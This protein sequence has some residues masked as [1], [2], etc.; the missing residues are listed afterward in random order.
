MTESERSLTDRNLAR[1]PSDH[2]ARAQAYLSLIRHGQASQRSLLL[3]AAHGDTVAQNLVSDQAAVTRVRSGQDLAEL[4]RLPVESLDLSDCG[5]LQDQDLAALG[6]LPLQS[7]SLKN[8]YQVTDD[9]LQHLASLPLKDLDLS[10]C[11]KILGAGLESLAQLELKALR[12]DGC[13]Q[14][15]PYAFRFLGDFQLEHLSVVRGPDLDE[16]LHSLK[17]DALRSL[18]AGFQYSAVQNLQFKEFPA[19][20]TLALGGFPEFEPDEPSMFN[21]PRLSQIILER[22]CAPYASFYQDLQQRS[23]LELAI[24]DDHGL[25]EE[26]LLNELAPMTSLKSLDI[27][28]HIF[29]DMLQALSELKLEQLTLETHNSLTEAGLQQLNREHLRK[30]T[31]RNGPSLTDN[32]LKLFADSPLE[33]LALLGNGV[34]GW[35]FQYLSKTPLNT[36]YWSQVHLPD[37]TRLD[38]SPL[39]ELQEL[40]LD[41]PAAALDVTRLSLE[42]PKLKTLSLNPKGQTVDSSLSFLKAPA[43]EA[44]KIR[45]YRFDAQALKK[46]TAL[47]LKALQFTDCDFSADPK[48]SFLKEMA[49]V[50]DLTLSSLT[51]VDP[52][53]MDS[54]PDKAL[55]ELTLRSLPIQSLSALSEQPLESLSLESYPDLSGQDLEFIKTHKL[56]HLSLRACH[57]LTDTDL[58]ALQNMPLKTLSLRGCPFITVNGLRSLR[59]LPL[60]S[61]NLLHCEGLPYQYQTIHH[62][63]PAVRGVFQSL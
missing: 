39:R 28:A 35:G 57:P 48:L 29:D 51:G 34:S 14:I 21:H 30:L 54:L 43:L 25:I 3:A 60:D 58:R 10:H 41:L 20:E 15:E 22:C 55:R 62:G 40:T 8:C 16:L 53:F 47:P 19:L 33:A 6:G 23:V 11:T 17:I 9:G 46:L 42:N 50:Q 44:L 1:D 31:I 59:H 32:A 2:E 13:G 56:R 12:L 5:S 45:G 4:C 24:E 63:R 61:L 26:G 49:E 36:V 38:F 27:R 37:D 52:E 18:H 7:L